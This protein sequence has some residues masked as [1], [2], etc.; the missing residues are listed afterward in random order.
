M[1]YYFLPVSHDMKYQAPFSAPTMGIVYAIKKENNGPKPIILLLKFSGS[2]F[3]VEMSLKYKDMFLIT[4]KKES[5]YYN[6]I[7][8]VSFVIYTASH[9]SVLNLQK[10]HSAEATFGIFESESISCFTPA[11]GKLYRF[12][13]KINMK[14]YVYL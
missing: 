13:V 5:N 2:H 6:C 7:R 3:L 8:V 14:F 4:E 12:H 10:P 11:T 1:C 9:S